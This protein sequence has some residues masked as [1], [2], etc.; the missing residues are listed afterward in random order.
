M[1]FRLRTLLIVLALGPMVLAGAWMAWKQRVAAK[2]QQQLQQLEVQHAQS[3]VHYQE[4]LLK[5][6]QL[7]RERDALEMNLEREKLNQAEPGIYFLGPEYV[8]PR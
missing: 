7:Q 3:L 2:L 6:E 4:S 8:R 5:L 1:R